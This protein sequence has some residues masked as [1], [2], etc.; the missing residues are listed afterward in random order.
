M[1]QDKENRGE[2]TRLLEQLLVVSRLVK[3]ILAQ[4][5]SSGS[6]STGQD[7][8]PLGSAGNTKDDQDLNRVYL[9]RAFSEARNEAFKT[10]DLIE[11]TGGLE[12]VA[13]LLKLNGARTIFLG[14]AE[15]IFLQILIAHGQA[16]QGLSSRQGAERGKFLGVDEIFRAVEDWRKDEPRLARF[17]TEATYP[18]V[19]RTVFNLRQKIL[20]VGA[21]PNLIETG[22]TGESGY[23][24]STSPRNIMNTPWGC[25]RTS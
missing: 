5:P 16:R 22:P 4:E 24:L 20:K 1:S 3:E 2:L 25:L 23:R 10:N 8:G 21:N 15:F 14:K 9:E 12:S 11:L 13:N 18:T 17:W 7:D 19:H 6:G